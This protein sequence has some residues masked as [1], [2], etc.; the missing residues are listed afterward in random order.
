MY[1]YVAELYLWTVSAYYLILRYERLFWYRLSLEMNDTS[2]PPQ[3]FDW[4]LDFGMNIFFSFFIVVL[5]QLKLVLGVRCNWLGHGA[6]FSMFV[7]CFSLSWVCLKGQAWMNCSFF[8][9]HNTERRLAFILTTFHSLVSQG[10]KCIKAPV[11]GLF[12]W[13][14]VWKIFYTISY[15]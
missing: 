2:C 6:C 11:Y 12:E 10:C 14:G 15:C 13:N 3:M 1:W 5:A 7:R 8:T 4:M 9:Y